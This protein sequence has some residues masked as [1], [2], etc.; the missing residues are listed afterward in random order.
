[1][2]TRAWFELSVGA[3]PSGD[4]GNNVAQSWLRGTVVEAQEVVPGEVWSVSLVYPPDPVRRTSS[5]EET[6]YVLE[7]TCEVVGRTPVARARREMSLEDP[8]STFPLRTDWSAY[9]SHRIARRPSTIPE[10]ERESSLLAH[11]KW[12]CEENYVRGI[13]KVWLERIAK[14]E[15]GGL[16]ERAVAERYVLACVAANRCILLGMFHPT[17]RRSR[18]DA[19]RVRAGVTVSADDG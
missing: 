1:M 12:A 15:G 8:H 2:L 3:P 4:A 11:L 7:A 14:S 6:L 10:Q 16:A 17:G 5:K 19:D 13:S 18:K 9:I